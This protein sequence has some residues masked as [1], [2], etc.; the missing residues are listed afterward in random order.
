MDY[1]ILS[2]IAIEFVLKGFVLGICF[3]YTCIC[4]VGYYQE[5]K[6]KKIKGEQ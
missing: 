3:S 5:R 6:L 1:N 2:A 4:C